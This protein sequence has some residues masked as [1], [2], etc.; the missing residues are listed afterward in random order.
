MIFTSIFKKSSFEPL[1]LNEKNVVSLYNRCLPTTT[2]TDF[3]PSTLMAKPNYFNVVDRLQFDKNKINKE[4]KNIMYLMGQL[5]DV[6][7]HKYLILDHSILKYDGTQWTQNRDVELQLLHLCKALDLM[8]PFDV[9]KRGL[10]SYYH[11]DIIPTLK[12]EDPSFKTWFK[13]NYR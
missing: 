13:E 2:T 3:E 7:K 1:D 11:E 10:M 4:R 12:P 9:G 5:R 8:D 6:H